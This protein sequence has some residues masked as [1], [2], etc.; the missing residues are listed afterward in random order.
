V[1]D[2]Y[3]FVPAL[4]QDLHVIR[5]ASTLGYAAAF[6][7][8]DIDSITVSAGGVH[9]RPGRMVIDFYRMTMR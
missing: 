6:A 9:P 2:Y 1:P 3:Q 4:E 8:P 7:P 5:P